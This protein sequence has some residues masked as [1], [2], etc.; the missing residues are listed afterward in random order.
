MSV[1]LDAD[2]VVIVQGITGSEGSKHTARML[3][4]GTRVVG[5]VNA[6]KAGTSVRHGDTELPVFAGVAGAIAATGANASIVFVPPAFAKDAMFEAIDAGIPL[7]VV[8]TEG[9]PVQDAAEAVARAR[10]LGNATRII[11][12]NC[13]GIITPTATGRTKLRW[14]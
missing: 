9:V 14:I 11:G 6:R 7:L 1:F 3:D 12:P 5:G 2:S 13:P 8:I 10:A 4:A